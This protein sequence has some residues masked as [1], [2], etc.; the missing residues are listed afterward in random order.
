M[1]KKQLFTMWMGILLIVTPILYSLSNEIDWIVFLIT[2][3]TLWSIA[4]VLVTG[5]LIYTF[6]CERGHAFWLILTAVIVLILAAFVFAD[7]RE[8]LN[9]SQT[10]YL[11]TKSMSGVDKELL[12]EAGELWNQERLKI[13][14]SKEANDEQN[15]RYTPKTLR[16]DSNT[17]DPNGIRLR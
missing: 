5:G 6:Q 13:A 8:H 15:R 14:N 3:L 12:R 7:Y 9:Q 17:Q 11:G 2:K 1:N 10:G 4:V 16:D